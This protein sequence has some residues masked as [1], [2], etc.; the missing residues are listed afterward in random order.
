MILLS[1]YILFEHIPI[2]CAHA[3]ECRYDEIIDYRFTQTPLTDSGNAMIGH[4]SQV[5]WK[6]TTK[7]GCYFSYGPRSNNGEGCAVLT[8][9][10]SPP[11]NWNGDS[12]YL[13]NVL[14]LGGAVPLPMPVP[15]PVPAPSPTPTPSLSD[16]GSVAPG[17]NCPD[18]GQAVLDT[19]NR[20]RA[21]HGVP[22]LVWDMGLVT[23]AKAWS[24]QLAANSC[25]LQHH[26]NGY[27][28]NLWMGAWMGSGL[29]ETFS[30]ADAT[31]DSW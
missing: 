2:P 13:A 27:G 5:V 12:Y 8:C 28:Q 3:R 30:C 11:G 6:D 19:H 4:F 14:P 1:R 31:T 18:G 25:E 24:K 29:P 26:T 21:L 20:L 17:S 9:N 16:E 22:P 23:E 7:L 15:V 10:Y